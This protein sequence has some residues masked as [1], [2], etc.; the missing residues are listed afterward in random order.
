[1]N[2]IPTIDIMNER[3]KSVRDL[4][5]IWGVDGILIGS[6][7]NRR[8][9][10]GF[11]GSAGWLLI[12]E[13]RALIGI[14]FRYWELASTQ[15]PWF[16]MIPFKGRRSDALRD[17]I[18][19]AN[20]S[21]LGLEA[22]HITLSQFKV[23]NSVGDIEWKQLDEAIESLRQVK[24][25]NEIA[26]IRQA[27]AITDQ[28]MEQVNDIIRPGMSEREVAWELEKRM[29]EL[30]ADGM[31]FPIIVASGSNAARAH[32]QPTNKTIED[33]DVI[34]VDM[35]AQCNGY[36]SDLTRTFHLGS[37]EDERFKNLYPLV[38]HAQKMA[39]ENLRPGMS[40]KAV[41]SLARKVIE[42]AGFQ[43]AFG[44]PLGHGLGL[45]VH[46]LPRIS[47]LEGNNDIRAGMVFTVEPG[48]YFSDWGGIRIEDLVY[49]SE[50][51]IELLSGCPNKPNI[52]IG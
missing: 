49:V 29:R 38:N 21:R 3:L 11:T 2:Q 10:S 45:E 8:W 12:T 14:D 5:P 16:E 30:G 46:E 31:A 44:H 6:S 25:M 36:C 9:L 19:S 48:V 24:S 42:A 51:G 43:D 4:I 18:K 1:M 28:V 34:I 37:E 39:L 15:A 17:F 7:A 50:D 35:G 40:G 23:L 22:Q 27:A 13:S 47:S 33:G 52:I 41:D 26:H 32:H 20:V